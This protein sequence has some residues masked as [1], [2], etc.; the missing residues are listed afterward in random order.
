[1]PYYPP[2]AGTPGGA[3]TQVQFNSSNA[4]GGDAN[5]VWDNT[6]KVL[7]SGSLAAFQSG[8]TV[9]YLSVVDRTATT[10]EVGRVYGGGGFNVQA[11]SGN[12]LSLTSGGNSNSQGIQLGNLVNFQVFISD[13]AYSFQTPVNG[14]SITLGD[15]TW[16][17]ILDP[18]GTLASGTITMPANPVDG[19]IVNVRCSQVITALTISPNTGQSVKGAP[20]SAAVG[21]TF[22][23][24]YRLANTTWYF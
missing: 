16:H 14:F 7:T 4:F 10:T 6:N 22:E 3:N 17:T 15:A 13:T 11:K 9:S 19:M 2:T 20:S 12:P 5:L 1:M 24:I 8:V 18:A 23:A 21:G